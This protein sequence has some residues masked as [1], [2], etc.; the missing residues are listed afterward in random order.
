MLYLA[1]YTQHFMTADHLRVFRYSSA[2]SDLWLIKI[3][4]ITLK[5][6]NRA[7][8]ER[9]LKE[10]LRKRME[11]YSG[12]GNSSGK[13]QNRS[14]RFYLETDLDEADAIRLLETTPGIV[15][16]SRA[17]KTE[18]T[19][20]AIHEAALIVAKLALA[21]GVGNRFKYEVRRTDKGLPMDSYGYARELGGML[22]E[23]LPELTVDVRKPDF[24]LKLELREKAYLYQRE[25]KG[26][27]GLPVS[28]AGRGMLL[29]SGGIDSPVAGYLMAKRG[30]R[31]TAV[32]FHTP[33]FTSPEAHDKVMRLASE[34]APWCEGLSVYSVPF[35]ECQVKIN[36]SVEPNTTTLHSRACMTQIAEK[37]AATRRCGGLVTGES[38]GQV[39]SQT[40]ESLAYTDGATD[41]PVFRPLIGMDKE[42]IIVLARKIGTFE[43]AIE[44]FDDCCTLFSPEHPLTRP[45]VA[46]QR[47]VY[48]SIEDLD[49]L[50]DKAISEAEVFR[51][52][53]LGRKIHR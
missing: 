51:Y 33:P 14:G 25:R 38:L 29:L 24:Y 10:N 50:M 42:E 1:L 28:T 7:Y 32:H 22:L 53:V 41:I 15:A 30:M 27:G 45:D 2:M 3:G 34:M 46:E 37:I 52:D 18:K 47:E 26:P 8:F 16:F 43:T 6:G 4:E 21:D 44:P 31:L 9:L 35:T 36:Q 13:V 39:A 48:E 23:D 20:E 11:Q 5:K 19:L 12:E 40:L 17:M 49:E